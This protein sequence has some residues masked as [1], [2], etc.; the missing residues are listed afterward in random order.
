MKHSSRRISV[1]DFKKLFE[2]V[3]GLYLI[4]SV[5]FEII[6]VSDAYL[7]ATMTH[8]ELIVGK[9]LFE[10]FPDNPNDPNA[11]GVSN[12]TKSLR[13]VLQLKTADN[14]PIQKYDIPKPESAGGGFEERY[15]KP[16]NTP[17]LDQDGEI[18]CI[19]HQVEDVTEMF[20]LQQS[21]R[22]FAETE[23]KYKRLIETAPDGVISIDDEG[24][25]LNWNLQAEKMFGWSED[26]VAGKKLSSTIIPERFREAHDRGLS[27]FLKAGEGPMLNKPIEIF[28][29]KKDG[30]HIDIELKISSSKINDR[31]VF[32][33]FLRDITES[34]RLN[35]ELGKN[36]A[37]LEAV[38]SELEALCYSIS[39]DLRTPL[40]AI[41]GYTKI[42]TSEFA[43]EF[44]DESKKLM[45]SVMQNARKMGQ[46]IDGLLTFSRIGRKEMSLTEVNMNALV[47]SVVHD[48]KSPKAVKAKIKIQPL[49][50]ITADYQ[51]TF[52]VVTNLIANAIK[53][54]SLKADPAIEIGVIKGIDA[55][56]IFFVKDNGAGFDM[57]YYSKL[58]GIFQ[59]LHSTRDFEG[60]GIGL[61]LTK[62]IITKH[63]GRIW[64]D[65]KL[66]QGAVFYFSLNGNKK[67][68]HE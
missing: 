53:F 5:D 16:V 4:L 60:T 39:H 41:H 63:G 33:G 52:Q 44:T 40:R 3:P 67:N 31:Y 54:S 19:I 37:R 50:S 6:A 38:N 29:L 30:G 36:V 20:S 64:A 65:S 28:A 24:L 62:R 12:L 2:S 49:P 26:E 34:K 10:V 21:K 43:S 15:W 11:T 68:K 57:K 13:H 61:A 59:R 27:N 14:M 35:S 47:D 58:F 46:L 1:P 23:A 51:F 42:I 22:T 56:H 55:D 8:R 9:G 18:W 32:I 25:I 45:D 48:L 7:R 66:D 17:A